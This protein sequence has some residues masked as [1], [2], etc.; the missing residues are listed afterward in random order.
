[1]YICVFMTYLIYKYI[2]YTFKYILYIIYDTF[3]FICQ[4][5]TN[6]YHYVN[7]C[8]FKRNW[9]ETLCLK[10]LYSYL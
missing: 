10:T 9:Y 3:I 6:N 2:I 5:G 7:I 1:M 4:D 8:I